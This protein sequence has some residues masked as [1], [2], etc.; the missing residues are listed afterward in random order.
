MSTSAEN[1]YRLSVF[2]P[3]IDHFNSQ[4]EI[5]FTKQKNT[6]SIIQNFI[7][8]KRIKLSGNEIETSMEVLEVMSKQWPI[9]ISS[10]D[11]IVNK[12]VLLWKQRWIAASKVLLLSFF[13]FIRLYL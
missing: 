5:R 1:Y 12:E 7:P 6:L 2:I 10:C 9:V 8:N 13:F 11:N 4:S 3:F